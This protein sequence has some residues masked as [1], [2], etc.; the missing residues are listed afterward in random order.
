MNI[1][2][3]ICLIVL[4]SLAHSG[5][6]GDPLDQF[7]AFTSPNGI[8]AA[9]AQLCPNFSAENS[10]ECAQYCLGNETCVSFAYVSDQ[11]ICGLNKYSMYYTVVEGGGSTM[12][13]YLRIIPQDDTPASIHVDYL[14][15][16]PTSNVQLGPSILYTTFENALEYLS[17]FPVDDLL[18]FFRMRNGDPNPPG[19]CWGW[20]ANLRGSIAGLYMMGTGNAVRWMDNQTFVDNM[21]AV[22]AG[23]KECQESNGYIMA[24]SENDTMAHENPDYVLSWVTHGLI[25][26][27]LGGNPDALQLI[28][29]QLTWFNYNQYLPE[30]MPPNTVDVPPQYGAASG[31][32]IYV[33]YQGII[34]NTR[35]AT[36]KMGLQRDVDVV[37]TLYQEDEWL[38]QLIER[39]TS[40]IWQKHWFPHNYEVTAFEAY[41]DMYILTGNSTY[42]DAITGAWEMFM[43]YFIH[44]GGSM[45]INEG[46]PQF[47]Y[48]P[49]SY[50]LEC[51]Y[52][53][54]AKQTES[55]I[56]T[57]ACS[58]PS[59][60]SYLHDHRIEYGDSC[61][62]TGETCGS[63]FWIKLN[64]RF[65]K[66]FPDEEKYPNEIEREIYNVIIANQDGGNGNRYFANLHKYKQASTN[67]GS[68]CESQGVRAWSSL[69]EY[70]YSYSSAGLYID[71]YSKSSIIFKYNSIPIKLLVETEFPYGENVTI[72]VN[73]SKTVSF[74]LAL[75]IPSWVN[76]SVTIFVNG[77][78]AAEG[79][80]G[81]YTKI[82]RTWHIRD[83]VEFT[84]PMTFRVTNYTGLTQIPPFSRYAIEYGPILL[85]V[86]GPWDNSTDSIIIKGVDPKNPSSWLVPVPNQPLHFT[87]RGLEGYTYLPYM[88]IST[89]MFEVYPIIVN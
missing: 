84:L 6:S 39:N 37:A 86:T 22:V 77:Q 88:E 5:A 80:P 75:R 54:V 16:T 12:G 25:E 8:Y 4:L 31:H 69:P 55:E 24:Y 66:L 15:Q 28:R 74:E 57:P 11:K 59:I 53:A 68:C 65:H 9:N 10:S 44:V 20:D 64:Q 62:A 17:M 23:I 70:L 18:Y 58:G 82:S 61:H 52:G 26:A 34:H 13:Y 42:L 43:E 56:P 79:T 3:W 2:T 87:I 76:Q 41:L 21:N 73:P 51:T 7:L 40:G 27:S 38:Q 71:L 67:V 48:P 46:S 49:G 36:S 60:N 85:A 72:L 14:L 19:Q 45:A 47:W 50:Y 32:S 63:V 29:D 30:F 89:Q 35:M 33:I 78:S 81:N 83:V 1:S